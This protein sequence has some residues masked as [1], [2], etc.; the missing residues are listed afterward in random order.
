MLVNTI[1]FEFA[2]QWL[3]HLRKVRIDGCVAKHAKGYY[4]SIIYTAHYQDITEISVLLV[5]KFC[6]QLLQLCTARTVF[7]ILV[8]VRLYT[9]MVEVCR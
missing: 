8:T 9:V 3:N 5:F 6:N 4:I 2:V 1:V 7:S